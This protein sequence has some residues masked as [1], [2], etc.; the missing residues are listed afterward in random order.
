MQQTVAHPRYRVVGHDGE[1]TNGRETIFWR[2]GGGAVL[3]T[4]LD[5]RSGHRTVVRLPRDCRHPVGSQEF[6]GHGWLLA[7][8]TPRRL[9]LYSLSAHRWRSLAVRGP[10]R[11]QALACSAIAVGSRWVEYDRAT[12]RTGDTF[13]FQ[14]IATE[15]VRGDPTTAHVFPDLNSSE[16]MRRVCAPVRVPPDGALRFQGPFVL[17]IHYQAEAVL[18]RCGTQL[19]ARAGSSASSSAIGPRAVIYDT[20]P[21]HPIGGITLPG[22]QRF[23][24]A[25]PREA[26]DV[27]A[28]DVARAHLYVD[29]TTRNGHYDVW[30]APLST[31]SPVSPR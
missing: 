1:Q 9:R 8:C 31:A 12:V 17:V 5:E 13:Y 11:R 28:V 7:D 21:H 30:S 3:G 6:I 24:I 18:Q 10:C 23:T 22:L 14:N 16:L 27:I 2:G 29:G 20:G 4:L 15:A 26:D 25:L 19:H